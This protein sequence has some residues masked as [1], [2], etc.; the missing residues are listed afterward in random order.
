MSIAEEYLKPRF[1]IVE[2][3]YSMIAPC[4]LSNNGKHWIVINCPHCGVPHMHAAVP[5]E[6]KSKH[7]LIAHRL[8]HCDLRNARDYV[9]FRVD[10]EYE[11]VDSCD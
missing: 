7:P 9:L 10:R 4:K 11:A 2:R 3:M 1:E 8:S 5:A 6:K